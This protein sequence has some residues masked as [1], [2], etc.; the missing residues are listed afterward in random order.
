[1]A[2]VRPFRAVRP[3]KEY[4]DRVI[5]LPY[6]VRTGKK[7]P[8]WLLEIHTAFFISGRSEIDLPHEENPYS[9][10]CLRESNKRT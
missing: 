10:G 4:A 3:A 8:I 7:R 2:I 5:S 6:D 1:M 9:G